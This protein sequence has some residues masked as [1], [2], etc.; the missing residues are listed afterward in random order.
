MNVYSPRQDDKGVYVG[1]ITHMLNS[2]DRAEKLVIHGDGSQ[3]YDF[4]DV[5][6]CARAN[7]LAMQAET[8]GTFYNVG[9]GIKTSIKELVQLISDLHPRKIE[10]QF[11]DGV[12]PFVRNRVGA[13]NNAWLDFKLS[14]NI[15]LNQGISQFIMWR[16]TD[17]VTK[18]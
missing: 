17:R 9:T 11:K 1:V 12:R 14:A 8:N 10:P 3:A 7:I 13:V 2:I 15:K 16:K 6:D 4:I 18:R 5:R